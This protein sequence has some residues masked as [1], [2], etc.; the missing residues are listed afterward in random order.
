MSNINFFRVMAKG[1]NKGITPFDPPFVPQYLMVTYEFTD[2]TDLDTRTRIVSPD[3][4]QTSIGDY[5]GYSFDT[6][7]PSS[8]AYLLWGGDN[9]GT[10]FESVLWYIDDF[11]T[12]YPS[13]NIVTLDFRAF[14]YTTTGSNPVNIDVTLWRGGTPTKSSFIW[15]NTT[16]TNTYNVAS[17]SKQITLTNNPPDP[18]TS[19]NPGERV[20]TL[21]YNISQGSGNLNSNDTTT[22]MVP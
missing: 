14:W 10:G 18:I 22:P 17:V 7:W 3:V 20:C 12:A 15:V 6:Q 16:A 8:S 5:L 11:A 2:G 9:T 19:N 4:G 1:G 21:T 13:N